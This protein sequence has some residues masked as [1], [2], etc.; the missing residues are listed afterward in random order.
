MKLFEIWKGQAYEPK[1]QADYEEFWG[2]YLP[3]EKKNYEYLLDH[4]DE[5]VSGTVGELAPKFDMDAVTFVGFLDGINS[6]LKAE[7]DVENLEESTNIALDIDFEKLYYNMLD[8]KAD[9]LHNLPQWEEILT[10]DQRKAIKKEY[11]K[12]KTIVK[13]DRIGRNDPCTCGS[14]KKYKKCCG[15]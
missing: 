2:A 1:S 6:S 12:T 11:D 8:A 4:K 5:I 3:M 13:G 15:K 14:G 10:V 7:L 9:W